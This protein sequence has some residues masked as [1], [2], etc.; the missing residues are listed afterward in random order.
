MVRSVRPGESLSDCERWCGCGAGP[1]LDHRLCRENRPQ[2]G[3]GKV[4]D[5]CGVCVYICLCT[6]YVPHVWF[7]MCVCS[8]CGVYMWYVCVCAT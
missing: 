6:M 2:A 7:V 4:C 3:K 5:V 1:P 8:M